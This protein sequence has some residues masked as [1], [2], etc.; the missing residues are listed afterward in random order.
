MAIFLLLK[1]IFSE[2]KIKGPRWITDEFVRAGLRIRLPDHSDID[3]V[4]DKKKVKIEP[5]IKGSNLTFNIKV[6][7][8]ATIL[9][10]PQYEK[11]ST[12][13]KEA[14]QK[15]KKQ[16]IE[17]Y[18]Q[19]LSINSDVYRL[20]HVLYKK[21]LRK[22]K[23]VQSNGAIPLTKDSINVKVNVQVKHGNKQRIGPTV[24]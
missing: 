8:K 18:A 2:N 19:G 5:V 21:E 3:L 11:L 12:I 16:I 17:T 9:V 7:A 24:D 10:M 23:A 15:I 1:G 20:S 14:E 22:W 13:K 4:V 6:R